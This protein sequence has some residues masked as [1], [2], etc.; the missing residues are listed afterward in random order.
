MNIFIMNNTKIP[1]IIHMTNKT[2]VFPEKIIN[3]WKKLNPDYKFTFSDDNDCYEFIEKNFNKSYAELFNN[4]KYGPNKAD[5]WRLCKLYVE[6]G[7]YAD[8]DIVPYV[9]IEYIIKD[10][11]FCSCLSILGNSVFQAFLCSTPKNILIKEC[12]ISFVSNVERMNVLKSINVH[13]V[14]PTFDMYNAIIKKL[15]IKKINPFVN[16]I[17]KVN[18]RENNNS[19]NEKIMFLQEFYLK[20][21]KN[22]GIGFRMINNEVNGSL[23]NMYVKNRENKIVLKSRDDAYNNGY[24][25]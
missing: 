8:I 14:Q 7:V 15:N 16:Y 24:N 25:H 2:N 13:N 12:I 9:N 6:G 10:S 18:D 5:F 11:T 19:H 22:N 17:L 4:I 21:A 3:M 23:Y 1:K 20:K